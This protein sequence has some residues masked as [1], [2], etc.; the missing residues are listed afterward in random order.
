MNTATAQ[1][2]LPDGTRHT[3]LD[4]SDLEL[5]TGYCCGWS[6]DP[7]VK[8]TIFFSSITLAFKIK[9]SVPYR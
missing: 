2:V 1:H 6:S 8:A 3:G 7:A 9:P 4:G 5:V